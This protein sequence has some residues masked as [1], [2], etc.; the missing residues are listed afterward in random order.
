MSA[1]QKPLSPTGVSLKKRMA[2]IT[3]MKNLSRLMSRVGLCPILL[4]FAANLA[5]AT[6]FTITDLTITGLSYDNPAAYYYGIVVPFPTTTDLG[7]LGGIYSVP[8]G[9]NASGQ[10]TGF[11][12]LA[13][14]LTYHAFLY[15]G[16]TM[17][18]LGTLGGSWSWGWGISA[19]GQVTGLAATAGDQATH[20]FLYSGTTIKDLGTLGGSGSNGIWVNSSGQA[21]GE[22][23]IMV[24]D[25][26]THPFLYSGNTMTDLNDLIDPDS[27]W[28]LS[29]VVVIND[30]GQ[31]AGTGSIGGEK[32]DFLLTPANSSVPDGGAGW[33]GLGTFLLLCAWDFRRRAA[34]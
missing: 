16:G 28:V 9:T 12:L 21:V 27:G 13:D 15:S 33:A 24:G 19:N 22:S 4:G 14:N 20:A 31:I 7:T 34:A 29:S 8:F 2:V 5:S 18:D 11:S 17:Q 30:A 26:T 3:I 25:P 32:H 10:V 1:A 6:S 23:E